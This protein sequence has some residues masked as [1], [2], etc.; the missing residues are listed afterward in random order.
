[1]VRCLVFLF[2]HFS[3]ALSYVTGAPHI[4]E[5]IK[6]KDVVMRLVELLHHSNINVQTPALRSVGNL[7]TGNETEMFL[8]CGVLNRFTAMFEHPKKGIR[9][10]VIWAL[11]NITAG[12]RKQIQAVIDAEIFPKLLIMLSPVCNETVDIRKEIYYVCTNALAGGNDAQ[13]QYLIEH[14]VIQ[15]LCGGLDVDS[16]FLTVLLEGLESILKYG[17]RTGTLKEVT[18]IIE[19]CGG[20][21]RIEELKHHRKEAVCEITLRILESIGKLSKKDAR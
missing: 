10:E 6:Q 16:N 15:Q 17:E 3:W 20:L 19:D 9:K 5:S 14:S 8:S 21:A 2:N 1:M 18:K 11:S 7:L 4:F 12:S 13:V